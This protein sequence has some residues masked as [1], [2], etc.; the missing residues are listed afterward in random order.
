MGQSILSSVARFKH[1][2]HCSCNPDVR[3]NSLKGGE[4]YGCVTSASCSATPAILK[5]VAT[6]SPINRVVA[7]LGSILHWWMSTWVRHRR[8]IGRVG[9]KYVQTSS[10]SIRA[11]S[12]SRLLT[13]SND[14]PCY[15]R[16]QRE[17]CRLVRPKKKNAHT[18][19]ITNHAHSFTFLFPRC[20]DRRKEDP[21]LTPQ[22]PEAN[23]GRDRRI[24]PRS[25]ASAPN[26]EWRQ[27]GQDKAKAPSAERAPASASQEFF[28]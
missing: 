2:E 16:N 24:E 6:G 13:W 12:I 1:R 9:K 26:T 28:H 21:T 20:A 11:G 23:T 25:W 4:S 7:F 10:S 19:H 3:N 15:D 27:S 17:A 22:P 18:L 8:E 14:T 5:A